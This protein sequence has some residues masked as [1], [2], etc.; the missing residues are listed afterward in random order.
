MKLGRKIDT[1]IEP[2][3]LRKSDIDK[4]NQYIR[5]I[6]TTWKKITITRNK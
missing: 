6:L 2:H 5:E 4:T 3:P 1:Q